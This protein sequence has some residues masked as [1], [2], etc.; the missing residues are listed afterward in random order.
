[1][2]SSP[3]ADALFQ[4]A[5]RCHEARRW[6]E[7]ESRYRQVLAIAPGHVPALQN[8]AALAFQFG[9]LDVAA[10]LLGRAIAERPSE[11]SLHDQMGLVLHRRGAMAEAIACYER[12]LALQ[13]GFA[14]ARA[15][16][17]AARSDLAVASDPDYAE[18]GGAPWTAE[19]SIWEEKRGADTLLVTFAGLGVGRS[20]PTFIFRKFLSPYAGVDKLFIR[21]VSMSWYL[22]G[23]PGISADV[24]ATARE[25]EA[26]T[27]GY[28]KVVFLG[29]SS[30]GMAA[31]LYGQLL[32]VSK[33]LAFAPQTTLGA[34]KVSEYGD[35]RWELRLADLRRDAG[36]AAYL[37]L[38][39]LNPLGIP[40]D[41]YYPGASRLDCAHAERI[42]GAAVARFPQPGTGHLVALQMRDN[43]TLRAVIER[44]L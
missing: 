11:P 42:T 40:V 31:I 13:P 23:L 1:M 14:D 18:V 10:Q 3:Q 35:E 8:L 19:D 43:G 38:A 4:E 21:D 29:C 39:T 28:R 30:G 22:R 7:A 36:L 27:R 32:R 33:V 12:A 44:E 25:L 17:D 9:A 37:D 20:P 6:P 15:H 24:P 2:T 16:L 5:V 41:L 34:S 26:R